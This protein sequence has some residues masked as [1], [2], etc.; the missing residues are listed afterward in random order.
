[1]VKN[2]VDR[3]F[4]AGYLNTG[5]SAVVDYF[6][7]VE[8]V[9]VMNGEYDLFRDPSG[10][11]N[12]ISKMNNGAQSQK[13]FK[14][15]DIIL[16][17]ISLD[18]LEVALSKKKLISSTY[19]LKRRYN[20]YHCIVSHS[21]PIEVSKKITN[22]LKNIK[23]IYEPN[24]NKSYSYL[25]EEC[26]SVFESDIKLDKY[27]YI[28]YEQFFKPW[29][30]QHANVLKEGLS[31]WRLVIVDRE[32][33]EQYADIIRSKRRK[34]TLQKFMKEYVDIKFSQA[35]LINYLAIRYLSAFI[36]KII[37]Y[38]FVKKNNISNTFI[39]INCHKRDRVIKF[40][41]YY[42]EIFKINFS[43]FVNNFEEERNN[44]NK[45]LSLDKIK[46]QKNNFYPEKSINN[47]I[48]SSGY[49]TEFEIN[50]F[51]NQNFSCRC[52]NF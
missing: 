29:E 35:G 16:N 19:Q 24:L 36:K 38:V 43:K 48:L 6:K 49:L 39:N 33:K 42:D 26:L 8:E 17:K 13:I 10:I 50:Y 40:K 34:K 45:Y 1:M 25:L 32:L 47:V 5:S 12:L 30:L 37:D 46:Y 4:V 52:Q 21:R 15:I 23:S 41:K 9:Y 20:L 51:A 44:I 31:N 3:I 27:K 7:D 28:L 14:Q 18:R 11:L 22:H 2:K